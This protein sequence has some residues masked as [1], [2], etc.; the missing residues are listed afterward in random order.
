MKDII[1]PTRDARKEAKKQRELLAQQK[2][3]QKLEKAKA[4]GEAAQ[5]TA[6]AL[7]PNKGRRSLV[8]PSALKNTLG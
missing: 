1:D 4:T 6:M 7:N 5:A 3:Q 8:N 2:Q